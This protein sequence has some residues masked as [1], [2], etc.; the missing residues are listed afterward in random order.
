VFVALGIF[1][2]NVQRIDSFLKKC[3]IGD[4]GVIRTKAKEKDRVR[5]FTESLQAFAPDPPTGDPPSSN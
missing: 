1:S 4:D 2:M 5:R 3:V